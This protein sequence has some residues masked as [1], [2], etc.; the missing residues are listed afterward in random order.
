MKGTNTRLKAVRAGTGLNQ[1]EFGERIGVSGAAV[2]LWE[3]GKREIPG[4]AI[5]SICR[6]FHV[7][8]TWLR[9]GAGEMH[10]EQEKQ[11]ELGRAVAAM[12]ADRPDSFQAAVIAALLRFDPDGPEWDVLERIYNSI[13]KE[14]GAGD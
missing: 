5:L 9:T 14:K 11:E 6:E 1:V 12:M 2:S 13:E 4:T 3:A 8:E 7:S 10:G